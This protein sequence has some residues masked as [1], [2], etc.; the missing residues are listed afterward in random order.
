MG[1][2]LVSRMP[3]TLLIVVRLGSRPR[4]S[5]TWRAMQQHFNP[6]QNVLLVNIFHS[7][8]NTRVLISL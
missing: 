8:L 6:I 4:P 3:K 2:F 1:G 7:S 5:S